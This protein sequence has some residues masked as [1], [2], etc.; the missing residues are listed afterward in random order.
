MIKFIFFGASLLVIESLSFASVIP[1]GPAIHKPM[2][3]PYD[4]SINLDHE[5]AK[6]NFNQKAFNVLVSCTR[7]GDPRHKAKEQIVC[8]AV[9][10]M[11]EP[12]K[13]IK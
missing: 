12:E 8:A 2:M 7:Q 4:F 10:V 3:L 1:L 5:L 6:Q 9:S 13:K 11:P